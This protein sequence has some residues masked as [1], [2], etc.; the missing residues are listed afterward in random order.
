M[1]AMSCLIKC[2]MRR[3]HTTANVATQVATPAKVETPAETETPATPTEAK[4]PADTEF[5]WVSL[6]RIS[7]ELTRAKST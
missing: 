3:K 1:K 5:G 7:R 6:T 4:A 2:M